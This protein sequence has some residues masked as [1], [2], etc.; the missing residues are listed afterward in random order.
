MTTSAAIE[1]PAARKPLA[2]LTGLMPLAATT[3][4]PDPQHVFARLR[5]EHGPVAPVELEPGVHAWLVM[6]YPE[7]LTVTRQEQVYSCDPDDWAAHHDGSLP[8]D[9]LLRPMMSPYDNAFFVNGERHRRLRAPISGGMAEIDQ[10]AMR[11]SV[12]ALCTDVIG[13][14]AGRG[15]ADLVA[16]YAAIVPVL[17]VA[18]RFGLDAVQSHELQAGLA[19]MFAWGADALAAREKVMKILADVV[20]ARRA[21]PSADLTTY[22]AQHPNLRGDA[23][24]YDTMVLMLVAANENTMS[25]IA[26]TL[27]LMLTDERFAGRLRGGRLGVDDAIDEVLWRDP[28]MTNAPA[29]YALRDTELAGQ[30]VRRGDAMILGL[31][32]ANAD[33]RIHPTG[34]PWREVGNRAHLSWGAG[35]H[36][37]PAQIPARLIVRTAVETALHLLPGV[38]LAIPAEELQAVPSPWGRTPKSIPVRFT[39]V[40]HTA[41]GES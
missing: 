13:S 14:F 4:C 2:E 15:E 10:R 11:R 40:R 34:E 24:V 25:C 3:A 36:A 17:A 31:T 27:R 29:R 6:G 41:D 32:A 8:A 23:E 28:P 33:P 19:A 9:S 21:T 18:D 35:P 20:A 26:Q 5:A 30:P 38:R 16:D 22:L 1:S 37:C 39:P 12:A 7:I